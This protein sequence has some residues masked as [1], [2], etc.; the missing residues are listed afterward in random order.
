[1]DLS[2]FA[3]RHGPEG[4]VRGK[5]DN[6]FTSVFLPKATIGGAKRCSEIFPSEKL[7]DPNFV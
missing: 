2:P 1:M 3:A 7:I 6:R 5:G 4:I